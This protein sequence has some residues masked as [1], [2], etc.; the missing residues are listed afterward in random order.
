MSGMAGEEM[1]AMDA[2]LRREFKKLPKDRLIDF[3]HMTSKNFWSLQNNWVFHIEKR[4]GH[5][6]AVELDSVC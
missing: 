4:F 3:V 5:D 6:V 1:G 2:W